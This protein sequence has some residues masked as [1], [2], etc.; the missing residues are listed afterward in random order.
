MGFQPLPRLS[1]GKR[2]LPLPRGRYAVGTTDV[3]TKNNLFVRCF[4]PTKLIESSQDHLDNST[5]FPLWLP[6]LEYADGYLRFKLT[7][8]MPLLARFFRFLLHDPVC[9]TN[10]NAPVLNIGKPLPVVI[11][12]HGMGAMRTT[13]SI[14]LTE[15][16]SS[17]HF[18]A[19]L[20]HKDGS[21]SATQNVDG[22][23]TFE[24]HVATE[25]IEYNVRNEQVNQRVQECESAF[26]LLCQLSGQRIEETFEIE[27]S[28]SSEFKQSMPKAQL[29]LN[30]QCFISG[31]S[32]GGA[33]ALKSIYTS[34]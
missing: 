12:S 34:K 13:Y 11:F 7:S 33:T 28:E 6:S 20:E 19:A 22:S 4:Y 5:N 26:N 25:E 18:V 3:M 31:H 24:R 21:G 15:L 23:F 9:P 30:D 17:G 27:G 29:D 1:N 14:L 2:H 8:G 10:H 32:F 16:A